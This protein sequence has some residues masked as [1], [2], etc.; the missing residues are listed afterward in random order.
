MREHRLGGVTVRYSEGPTAESTVLVDAPPESVWPLVTDIHLVA[1]SSEELQEVA[2]IEGDGSGLGHRFRG[3]N[4]HPKAGE[5]ETVSQVTEY[6]PG[7]AFGWTVM[8]PANPTAVWRFELSPADE[9][10]EVRQWAR[11]GPGPSNLTGIIAAMPDKEERIVA[12]RLREWQ[13]SMERTL[14]F[15]KERAER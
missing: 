4:R 14:A 1:E 9:G 10:T 12:G 2:W 13:A 3:R 5:W 15:I 6:E 8:D 7:R 11:M